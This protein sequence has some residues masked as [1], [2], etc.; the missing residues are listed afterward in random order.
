MQNIF[1]N[2][3]SF[4][5]TSIE[6]A[7]HFFMESFNEVLIALGES[8]RACFFHKN[9]SIS[10]IQFGNGITYDD[11]LHAIKDIDIDIYSTLIEFE[12]KNYQVISDIDMDEF[13]IKF[14]NPSITGL[15]SKNINELDIVLLASCTHSILMSLNTS[16]IWAP[17]NLTVHYYADEQCSNHQSIE[18]GNISQRGHG[19]I[20]REKSLPETIEELPS[21][22][23]N[24][25]IKIFS[26]EHGLPHFH[27]CY[28]GN[29]LASIAIE[30]FETIVGSV[31]NVTYVNKI[32]IWAKENQNILRRIWKNNAQPGFSFYGDIH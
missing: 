14:N 10:E 9:D 20:W 17:P 7:I 19:Q 3:L 15:G 6:E 24:Y 32:I 25:S 13:Y 27:L 1:L 16:A 11:I 23:G 26:R 31:P 12:D 5:C 28:K 8:P 4:S 2:D 21:N 30:T 18:V 29:K 22:I